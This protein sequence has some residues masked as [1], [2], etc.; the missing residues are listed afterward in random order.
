M[1]RWIKVHE[2]ARVDLVD[3]GPP[4]RDQMHIL[5][6]ESSIA[7]VLSDGCDLIL[8]STNRGVTHGCMWTP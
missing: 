5:N 6:S 7:L 1:E 4:D 2:S 3:L 8:K